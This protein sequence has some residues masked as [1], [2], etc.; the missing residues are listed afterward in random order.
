[1][2]CQVPGYLKTPKLALRHLVQNS[3]E[4]STTAHF[5]SKV[6]FMLSARSFICTYLKEKC[7]WLLMGNFTEIRIAKYNLLPTHEGI[8]VA[9]SCIY[10]KLLHFLKLVTQRE[11][12]DWQRITLW[13]HI[14]WPRS[15]QWREYWSKDQPPASSLASQALVCA[16]FEATRPPF[17]LPLPWLS[18]RWWYYV[19]KLVDEGGA[20]NAQLLKDGSQNGSAGS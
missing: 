5:S 17:P 10:R 18:I 16:F 13:T 8:V 1:M 3:Q 11:C 4:I 9:H 14:R 6:C 12:S 7:D 19:C 20:R 15:S 2:M